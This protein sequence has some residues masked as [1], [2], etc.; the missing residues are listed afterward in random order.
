MMDFF[1]SRFRRKGK[2][3]N[4]LH[5]FWE[6]FQENENSFYHVVKQHDDIE[7][8]F[9]NH[10]K[11]KLNQLREGIWY[12]TGMY[13]EEVAELVITPDGVIRNIAF[14]E[15]LV[16]AAP[17]L[18][19]WKFTA[20]KPAIDIKNMSIEMAGYT[21]SN[22]SLSFYPV[23]NSDYP[24]EIEIH[25]IHND[26]EEQNISTIETGVYIFLDN[27]LGELNAATIIDE[28]RVTPVSK[29][30]KELIPIAKLKDFLIWR[31]KEFVEK[32]TGIR[33]DT[34]NDN[35]MALEGTLNNGLP[36]LA[37]VNSDLLNWDSKASHPWI[38][39]VEIKYDGGQNNGMPNEKDYQLLNEIEDQL[40]LELK[41]VEG[42]LNIGRQTADS[43]REVYFACID[44]RKPSEVLYA[45][46]KDYVGY[47]VEIEFEI[48]KDNYWQSFDRFKNH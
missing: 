30:E 36:L 47:S 27:Y 1:K 45:L 32:Y 44:F 39:V 7:R 12:L 37:L 35:Y 25:I 28:L 40:M 3:M 24:D 8:N 26:G 9:F 19:K 4:S 38:T 11:P 20:L 14:V 48:Y 15:K 18:P 2:A 22:D 29:A 10:L 46:Q 31:E 41:D 17:K 42:Y 23:D 21:F 33:N 34:E 43:L 16:Q 5:D 13:D 6:W